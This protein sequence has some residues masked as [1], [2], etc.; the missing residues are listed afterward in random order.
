MTLTGMSDYLRI[1]SGPGWT[2]HHLVGALYGLLNFLTAAASGISGRPYLARYSSAVILVRLGWPSCC[3]INHSALVYGMLSQSFGFPSR[4]WAG[5]A[6]HWFLRC[7]LNQ[8]SELLGLEQLGQENSPVR[9]RDDS[10]HVHVLQC[11]C[12]ITS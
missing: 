8:P 2:N 6:S 7:H 12:P 1:A 3:V 10:W 11:I 4:A 9:G 5:E